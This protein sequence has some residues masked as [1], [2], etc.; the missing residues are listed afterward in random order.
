VSHFSNIQTKIKNK[1]Y[2]E[3]AL[4]TLNIKFTQKL[5]IEIGS[6]EEQKLPTLVISEFGHEDF[7]FKWASN[8]YQFV[9]DELMWKSPLNLNLFTDKLNEIYACETIVQESI[10]QNFQ[11]IE[12]KQIQGSTQ[13]TFE[14]YKMKS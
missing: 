2:L 6:D 10:K 8:H 11:L 4:D 5:Q 12:E 7:G 1:K 14:R 13:Y 9:V 3:N